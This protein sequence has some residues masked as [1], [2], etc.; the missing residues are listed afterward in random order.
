MY[1]TITAN[2][3]RF[4]GVMF[5]G[6]EI[7]ATVDEVAPAVA[8]N[9]ERFMKAVTKVAGVNDEVPADDIL[10]FVR[11]YIAQT[12]GANYSAAR[13]RAY[14]A[15]TR[16]QN[17]A[18]AVLSEMEF[19]RKRGGD[20]PT[21]TIRK[22]VVD[23]DTAY[24]YYVAKAHDAYHRY[25]RM[26]NPALEHAANL[27]EID[28]TDGE[29]T[30]AVLNFIDLTAFVIFGFTKP[31]TKSGLNTIAKAQ[32]TARAFALANA[33]ARGEKTAETADAFNAMK[34]AF[35]ATFETFAGA[36]AGIH[37]NAGETLF[38]AS[39]FGRLTFSV[40]DVDAVRDIYVSTPAE[41]ETFRDVCRMALYKLEGHKVGEEFAD[42]EG[43]AAE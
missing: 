13:E 35:I 3:K 32:E 7:R 27:P 15:Y 6:A 12:K 40:G 14:D 9:N 1:T 24:K 33:A 19:C 11:Y 18:D 17:K 8:W 39:I 20:A 10:D 37:F 42:E 28:W 43:T 21:Y 34:D 26:Y 25:D 16:A 2:K 36:G 41:R 5:D 30:P 29:E 31:L 23:A 4:D 22:Q 38:L